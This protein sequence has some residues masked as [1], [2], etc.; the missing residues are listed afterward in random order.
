MR[1]I[2]LF[3]HLSLDGIIAPTGP[4]LDADY[5]NGGWT[6]PYRS[7]AGAAA[8]A[9]AQGHGFDLLLGRRT[10]DLW[11]GYWPQAPSSPIADSLNAATKYVATHRPESLAWGPAQALGSDILKSIGQLKSSDG[12][13]LIIWGSSTLTSL[14]LEE[15]LADEVVLLVYP[16]LLGRGIRFFS[17][18]ASARRLEPLRTHALS[19]GVLMSTYRHLG[20]L[21]AG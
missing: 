7:P 17:E 18:S 15:A 16:V 5:T 8:V 9:E 20:A 6:S 21:R 12:P 4:E 19:S 14:L 11:S 2:R 10:Y 1:K 13:D 3:A